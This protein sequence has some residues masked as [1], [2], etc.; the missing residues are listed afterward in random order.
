[1]SHVKQT[2]KKDV[3]VQQHVQNLHLFV[4]LY[5]LMMAF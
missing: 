5:I 3:N 4:F 2:V 1:V